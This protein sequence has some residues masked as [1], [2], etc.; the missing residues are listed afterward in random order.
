MRLLWNKMLRDN[1]NNKSFPSVAINFKYLFLS[2]IFVQNLLK[3]KRVKITCQVLIYYRFLWY[4]WPYVTVSDTFTVSLAECFYI[5]VFNCV[6]VT[7]LALLVKNW[8]KKKLH[9]Y[10]YKKRICNKCTYIFRHEMIYL[11]SHDSTYSKS[12]PRAVSRGWKIL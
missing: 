5:V 3:I 4:A 6:N 12:Y 8:E 1:R 2:I 7:T 11:W 10:S 9:M